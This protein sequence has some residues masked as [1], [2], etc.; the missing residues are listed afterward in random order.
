[1]ACIAVCTTA[2][3]GFLPGDRRYVPTGAQPT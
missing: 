2:A 1:M 3:I